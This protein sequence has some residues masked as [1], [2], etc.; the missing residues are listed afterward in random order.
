MTGWRKSIIPVYTTEIYSD[1]PV[2][3]QKDKKKSNSKWL[4]YEKENALLHRVLKA[5]LQDEF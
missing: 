3:T 2:H 1:Y 4:S 5:S